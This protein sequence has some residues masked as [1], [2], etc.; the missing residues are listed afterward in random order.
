MGSIRMTSSSHYRVDCTAPRQVKI[1]EVVP[2]LRGTP[3]D[4]ITVVFRDDVQGFGLDDLILTRTGDVST[5]VDLISSA[6]L[7][8][9]DNETWVLADITDE[10]NPSGIY[11]LAL[12]PTNSGIVFVGGQP[13]TAG[14]TATWTTR[15]GDSNGDGRFDQ[16]DLVKVLQGAV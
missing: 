13:L 6:S 7:T 16:L 8:T 3:V 5:T 15:P 9:S 10:T 4:Q 12:N 2:T 11:E 14:A 1:D